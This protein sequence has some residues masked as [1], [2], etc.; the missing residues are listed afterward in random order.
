MESKITKMELLQSY[1]CISK[2]SIKG[3][4]NS[5]SLGRDTNVAQVGP[6]RHPA[7]VAKNKKA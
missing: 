2:N 3:T 4:I 7:T 6:D 1:N 5:V